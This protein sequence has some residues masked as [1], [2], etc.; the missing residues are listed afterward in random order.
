[1]Q[2]ANYIPLLEGVIVAVLAFF[3][4]KV[5]DEIAS[6]KTDIRLEIATH[7][8]G[9]DKALENTREDLLEKRR[10]LEA[11]HNK[12]HEL[13]MK[14]ATDYVNKGEIEGR[15]ASLDTRL[16]KMDGALGKLQMHSVSKEDARASTDA[17]LNALKNER[18]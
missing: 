7:K 9:L 2:M 14:M 8:D 10:Q 16:T 13:A 3:L 1:M 12:M 18:K 6:L 5:F 15:F 17:I 11:A 4:K